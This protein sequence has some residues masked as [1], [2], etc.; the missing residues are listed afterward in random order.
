LKTKRLVILGSTGSIG[1]QTLDVVRELRDHFEIIGLAAGRNSSLLLEQARE[2]QPK[3]I[4]CEDTS[5]RAD[6][7][8][9]YAPKGRWSSLEEQAAHPDTDIVVVGTVGKAGLGATLAALEAGKT[10]AIANKEVL[11][12]AGRVVTDAAKRGKGR[13]LPVDS[14]HSAIWQCLWGE[15]HSSISRIILTASGGAFR[16][17][18]AE[19]LERVSPAEAL[20]HPT[21]QMGQKITVD[22]ATLLNKGFEAIETRW[23]FDV[24]L[25]QIEIVLHRES[26]VHSLVE[27]SDGSVKAQLGEPDMRLPIRVALAYPDRLAVATTPFDLARTAKLHFAPPDFRRLPALALALKAGRRGGTYPAA[28]A[29]AAEVAVTHFLDGHLSFTD[30]ARILEDTLSAHDGGPDT[31]LEAILEADA[32]ARNYAEDWVRAKV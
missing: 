20:N 5:T 26:I 21:W 17:Y 28:L 25:E 22:S 6:L 1:Q 9:A 32:W 7:E 31:D 3:L 18:T 12:M 4:C 11:V 8:S 15:K 30:I 29:A 24:P 16:D 13:L 27:F 10:V 19:Q 2:F 14:E 23:L